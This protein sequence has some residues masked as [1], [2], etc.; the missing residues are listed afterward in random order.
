[1]TFRYAESQVDVGMPGFHDQGELDPVFAAPAFQLAAMR[2]VALVSGKGF[3]SY[4]RTQLDMFRIAEYAPG[5][6][7]DIIPRG[8][9]YEASNPYQRSLSH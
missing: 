3:H 7:R 6:R 2:K 4:D 1:M 9:E 5:L 8:G